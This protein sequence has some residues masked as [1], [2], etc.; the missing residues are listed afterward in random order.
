MRPQPMYIDLGKPSARSKLSVSSS[1]QLSVGVM[2]FS[3]QVLENEVLTASVVARKSVRAA[4][5][6]GGRQ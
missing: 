4:L 5:E 1:R 6:S 3:E 2:L